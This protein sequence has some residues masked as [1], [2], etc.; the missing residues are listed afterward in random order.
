M[1]V[2]NFLPR[3]KNWYLGKIPIFCSKNA[4]LDLNH[5]V[6]IFTILTCTLVAS[7]SASIQNHLHPPSPSLVGSQI[8]LLLVALWRFQYLPSYS[9]WG[10]CSPVQGPPKVAPSA[11]SENLAASFGRCT[12]FSFLGRFAEN[13]GSTGAITIYSN[14]ILHL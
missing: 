4:V 5:Y 3:S 7:C 10:S 14:L 8:L 6:I 11:L 12:S 9:C 2:I 1:N 13:Y